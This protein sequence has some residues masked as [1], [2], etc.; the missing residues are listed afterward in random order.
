MT[1]A[2]A[3]IFVTFPEI[4]IGNESAGHLAVDSYKQ[5]VDTLAIE[6]KKFFGVGQAQGQRSSIFLQECRD[7]HVDRK[8]MVAQRSEDIVGKFLETES[9]GAEAPL[10]P[11]WYRVPFRSEAWG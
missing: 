9:L 3:I 10:E 5:V 1:Q 11:R 8:A 6:F 2:M 4:I 7:E